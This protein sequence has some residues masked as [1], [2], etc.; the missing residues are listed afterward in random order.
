MDLITLEDRQYAVGVLGKAV[1]GK[2]ESELMEYLATEKIGNASLAQAFGPMFEQYAEYGRDGV[3]KKMFHE[4][5]SEHNIWQFKKGNY[6]LYC[7]KDPAEKRL[8]VLCHGALKRSKKAK[9]ADIENAIQVRD[10]YIDQKRRGL[11]RRRT[12]KEV[13]AEAS[14]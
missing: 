1:N 7:F 2:T 8:I 13:E 6:R 10:R 5:S 4:A 12:L 14:N 11:L 3:T 9:K